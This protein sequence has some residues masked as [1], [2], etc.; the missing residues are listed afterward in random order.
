MGMD[1]VES[2]LISMGMGFNV[3]GFSRDAYFF[4]WDDFLT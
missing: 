2:R 1:E 3:V 4:I